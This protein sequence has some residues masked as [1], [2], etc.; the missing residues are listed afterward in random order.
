MEP[1]LF[2]L[3]FFFP[4]LFSGVVYYHK[5]QHPLLARW[6]SIQRYKD[7]PA[8]EL[9][10]L[11]TMKAIAARSQ[12]EIDKE[13]AAH[14]KQLTLDRTKHQ[15]A[16]N[17]FDAAF[18]E[19]TREEDERKAREEQAKKDAQ[20]K[21]DLEEA[22]R[23]RQERAAEIAE[24]NAQKE[25][26]RIQAAK[27]WAENEKIR[28]AAFQLQQA[29]EDALTAVYEVN[30]FLAK[31]QRYLEATKNDHSWS[32]MVQRAEFYAERNARRVAA[33]VAEDSSFGDRY[34]HVHSLYL[35]AT[36]ESTG[37]IR[38]R[39]AQGDKVTVIGWV[40]G[41]NYNTNEIWYVLNDGSFGFSFAWSGG[42]SKTSTSGLPNMT[43]QLRG[44][45][46][47]TE[48]RNG[49]GE[50]AFTYTEYA[51]PK[52]APVKQEFGEITGTKMHAAGALITADKLY[53]QQPPVLSEK[54][55][56]EKLVKEVIG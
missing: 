51:W 28:L 12:A 1:I 14:H 11:N 24:A 15:L 9:E 19:I 50:V 37:T 22:E 45:P 23:L 30:G 36:P 2:A 27:E 55:V 8:R 34:V 17:D 6:R 5:G 13:E 49:A 48:V 33:R 35:R 40:I 38:G 18:K 44:E 52:A 41:Q 43:E 7:V 3:L 25:A 54:E 4:T 10:H 31:E 46:D 53:F 16:L 47:I 56:A 42:F 29:Q 21:A 26:Q 32:G 20:I 39:L